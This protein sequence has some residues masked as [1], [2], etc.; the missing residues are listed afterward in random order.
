MS[1]PTPALSVRLAGAVE[2]H[3]ERSDRDRCQ[4]LGC[5]FSRPATVAE[6]TWLA[7]RYSEM[8][9]RRLL[10]RVEVLRD[11]TRR[12]SWPQLAGRPQRDSTGDEAD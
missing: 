5:P 10:T 11:G 7:G 9:G 8:P 12:R 6:R 3:V 2:Q 1:A 4:W